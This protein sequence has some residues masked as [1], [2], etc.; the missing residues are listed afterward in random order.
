M[1]TILI[2]SLQ[3][4]LPTAPLTAAAHSAGADCRGLKDMGAVSDRPTKQ[5]L[6]M[7]G[8]HRQQ[9]TLHNTSAS[10]FVSTQCF[11][12]REVRKEIKVCKTALQPSCLQ[13]AAVS[14]LQNLTYP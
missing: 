13:S 2:K 6:T 9:V 7:L 10:Q 3:S 11:K 4:P 14:W 1:E 8:I 5:D 12:S